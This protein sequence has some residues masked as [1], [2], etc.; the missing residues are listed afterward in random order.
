MAWTAATTTGKYTGAQPA[1]TAL[2]ASFA[3][4]VAPQRGGIAPSDDDGSRS[5][6]ASICAT[7]ASVGGTMGNPSVPP[8]RRNRWKIASGSSSTVMRST[9]SAAA[10]GSLEQAA[11]GP[12]KPTPGVLASVAISTIVAI[13]GSAR[14]RIS[15]WGTLTMG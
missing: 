10:T 2:T 14:R 3:I 13:T 8:S 4:V 15:G 9:I 12:M 11:P 1:I 5:T 6:A 7:R